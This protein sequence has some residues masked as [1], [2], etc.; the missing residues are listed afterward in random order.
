MT[1]S[2]WISAHLDQTIWMNKSALSLVGCTLCTRTVLGFNKV[3]VIK[4][5]EKKNL[6]IVTKARNTVAL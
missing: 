2:S 6:K 3:A 5:V 4:S 1:L